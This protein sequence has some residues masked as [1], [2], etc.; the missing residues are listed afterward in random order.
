MTRETAQKKLNMIIWIYNIQ[1]IDYEYVFEYE[2]CL[3]TIN[4]AYI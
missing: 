2:I 4:L 1:N 3:C